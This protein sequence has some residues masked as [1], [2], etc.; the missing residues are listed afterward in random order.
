MR[1]SAHGLVLSTVRTTHRAQWIAMSFT[2]R[3]AA[4][5]DSFDRLLYFRKF[6]VL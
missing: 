1:G 5:M 4:E 6:Y 3:D 2:S